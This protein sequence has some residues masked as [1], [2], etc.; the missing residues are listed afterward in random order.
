MQ[1]HC[2]SPP[3]PGTTDGEHLVI[4]NPLALCHAIH[5]SG[6]TSVTDGSHRAAVSLLGL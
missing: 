6:G 2:F 3:S 1:K 5:S 4:C